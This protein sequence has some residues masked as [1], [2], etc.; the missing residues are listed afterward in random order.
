[1]ASS[2]LPADFSLFF[3]TVFWINPWI[4]NSFGR[5]L[6]PF[7][8]TDSSC[9]RCPETQKRTCKCKKASVSDCK[10]SRIFSQPDVDSRWNFQRGCFIL[11]MICI[12][13]PLLISNMTSRYFLCSVLPPTM[14]LTDISIHVLT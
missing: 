1:M 11:A 6:F 4:V 5:I 8:E 13:S 10:C 12:C 14:I 7:P 3:N 9:L 2:C